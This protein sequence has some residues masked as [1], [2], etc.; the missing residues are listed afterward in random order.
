MADFATLLKRAAIELSP[1][2]AKDLNT[3]HGLRNDFAHFTPKG[4]S[5]ELAGLPRII[6]AALQLVQELMQNDRVDYR[7][8]GNRKRRLRDNI[9]AI[10][11]GLEK[12]L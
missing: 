9:K 7:M 12:M 11:K 2:V 3:L 4:W 5:I 6:G 8:T 1:E 10:T